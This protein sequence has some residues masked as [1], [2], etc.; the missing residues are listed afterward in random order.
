M[1]GRPDPP[2]G[3]DD[4]PGALGRPR[5]DEPGEEGLLQLPQLPDGAVGRPGLDRLHGRPHDRRRAGPQRPAPVPL[6]RDEGR[7]RDHGVGGRR[8]A[9]RAGER[10][11]QGPPAAGAHVPRQPRRRP[12]H[13]RRPS[14]STQMASA[15]PYGE[16]LTENMQHVR[17]AC[18]TPSRASHLERRRARSSSRWRSATPSRT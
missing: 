14:S 8:A 13:R 17:R 5:V 10:A 2:R 18:P 6:L 15:K 9:D 3:D 7:L 12:D 16:W 4:D 11:A 1:A